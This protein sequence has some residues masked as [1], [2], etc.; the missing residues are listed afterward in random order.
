MTLNTYLT[1]DGRCKEAFELYAK[2][3]GGT[4]KTLIPHAGTPAAEHVPA[5]WQDKVMHAELAVGSQMLMGSDAP[6]EH[7]QPKSGFSVS[8][9]VADPAEAERI[10]NGLSA[11]GQ[12]RM[13]LQETFW[14]LKFGMLTDRFGTPWMINCGKPM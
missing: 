1:F 6:P 7:S 14:A 2:V 8:L 3:L 10:Y 9:Q 5:N 13:P 4:I 12:V 11:G